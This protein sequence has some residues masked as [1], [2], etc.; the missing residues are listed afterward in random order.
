MCR[1]KIRMCGIGCSWVETNSAF[2]LGVG[3]RG[4]E[5]ESGLSGEGDIY[6]GPQKLV[7][8][9]RIHRVR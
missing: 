6:T 4:L 1:I 2:H 5:S 8:F 9:P 7:P 3:G